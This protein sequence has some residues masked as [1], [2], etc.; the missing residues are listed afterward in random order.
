MHPERLSPSSPLLLVDD[1]KS[2]LHSLAATLEFSAGFNH[3]LLCHDSRE[4]LDLLAGREVSV[5]L[6]DLTM[7][8]LSGEELLLLIAQRHPEIPVIV[9]SG[10]NQIETAVRCMKLGAFDYFVK[11]EEKERLLAGIRRA[12][13]VLELRREN[14]QLKAGLLDG[15]LEKP[16]AF[17]GIV[18]ADPRMKSLLRYAEAIAVSPEPVLITGESGTGKELVAKAL[19]Q[20]C[21]PEAPW[22]AVNVAGLDDNV[23]SDTLFGH[24][25][26]AFTG[27]D[28]V[29]RGLIEQAAGGILFL[30]EIG[31]LS[32]ASQVKLL[33]LL[34]EGEYYPLGSDLP[35]TV[36]VRIVVATNQ[37][38]EA[39]KA[40]GE[41]RND[42]YYR[43]RIHRLHI[44]PL[45][46]RPD[47]IPL[48]L[49]SFLDQ[50][51]ASLGKKKPTAPKELPSLL[52][53]HPFPGNIRELR[54]MVY[55]AVSTHPGGVLSMEPF[56]KTI[57]LQAREKEESAT[58]ATPSSDI[59]FPEQ[60]PSLN[61]VGRSL[62]AEAM[63]R[64]KGN[65]GV[66]AG[67]L[68][69]SRQALNK[70]INQSLKT[71]LPPHPEKS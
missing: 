19:H 34:Q 60:L 17:A 21:C 70:R 24:A 64:A 25:R 29:R 11:T 31:D 46:E 35:K 56:K 3:T 58:A 68:G 5:I 54:A 20:L 47:D 65:Q 15:D 8:H 67:L 44:P 27:A 32:L 62:V 18:A 51:A 10:M 42:L 13:A 63:R 23:F 12:L 49:E 14:R 16:Q 71:H 7:P 28:Q 36:D 53:S 37:D 1:E 48:L 50:A 30:D 9:I 2:W 4:V 33:R 6:L 43:L 41:F 45:R 59:V 40:R 57:G 55:D 39:S 38:L 61:E 26:G 52:A 69:I 22:V 66:A